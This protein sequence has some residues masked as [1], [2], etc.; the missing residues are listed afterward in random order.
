MQSHKVMLKFELNTLIIEQDRLR[1]ELESESIGTD[2]P[3]QP[4]HAPQFI[5]VVPVRGRKTKQMS[6]QLEQ[7][8]EEEEKVE[9]A[10][11]AREEEERGPE[12]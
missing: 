4:Q 3:D 7:K 6:T 5:S 2:Q 1:A 10:D 9:E 11:N 12:E 8:K